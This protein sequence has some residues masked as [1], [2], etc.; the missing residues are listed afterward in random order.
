M[1]EWLDNLAPRER[2][3]VLAVAAFLV[4]LL[5]YLLIWAP[6]RGGYVDLR[7]TVTDQR[8]T[9]VW[10]QESAQLLAQLKRSGVRGGGLGGQSLLS[11]ADSTARAGGLSGA[12]KRVEPE[13]ADS[14]RVWLEGAAFDQVVRWLGSLAER[15]GIS[16]DTASIERVADA[17]GRVNVRLTLQ[18]PAL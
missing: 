13:G 14:V 11:L 17:A 12:L 10:M 5:A 2:M 6:L 15:Y 8:A 16:A 9:A 18:A 7:D 4:L 1:K 3:M